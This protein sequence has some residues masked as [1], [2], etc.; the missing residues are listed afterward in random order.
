M[1]FYTLP[2][3]MKLTFFQYKIFSNTRLLRNKGFS[4]TLFRSGFLN[5][6]ALTFWLDT[7]LFWAGGL[8]CALWDVWQHLWPLLTNNPLLKCDI[9]NIS[10]H[11]QMSPRG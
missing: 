10:W 1:Q 11:C 6:D 3:N 7:S 4:D 2:Q 9:K 5:S 8:S